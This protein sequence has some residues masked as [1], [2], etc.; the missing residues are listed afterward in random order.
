MFA[1]SYGMTTKG[2]PPEHLASKINGRKDIF[3]GWSFSGNSSYFC[4]FNTIDTINAINAVDT[5]NTIDPTNTTDTI[6]TL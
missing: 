6:S 4:I 5:I 1:V 2:P 3:D